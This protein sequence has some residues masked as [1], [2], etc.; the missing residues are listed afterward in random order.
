MTT[1]GIQ[2]CGDGSKI[3]LCGDGSKVQ[4]CGP[5]CQWRVTYLWDCNGE[6][7]VEVD[8]EFGDVSPDYPQAGYDYPADAPCIV[9]AYGDPAHCDADPVPELPAAPAALTGDALA[10][11]CDTGAVPEGCPCVAWPGSPQ[12]ADFPCGGLSYEYVVSNGLPGG[13]WA[14]EITALFGEPVL[15]N[16]FRFSAPVVVSA[17]ETSCRWARDDVM[18]ETRFWSSEAGEWS[19]W[20]DYEQ[21]TVEVRLGGIGLDVW[22]IGAVAAGAG[23]KLYGATPIGQY[24]RAIPSGNTTT[25]RAFGVSEAAP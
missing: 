8:S 7:W 19:A 12:Q 21:T 18:I 1:Y 15:I 17:S 23:I 9:Y 3:Q 10:A 16:E 6:E 2:T 13:I 22:S 25:I 20:E 11:C 24:S 4:L 5:F 14:R